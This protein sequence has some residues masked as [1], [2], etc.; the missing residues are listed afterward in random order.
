VHEVHAGGAVQ[1]PCATAT[2]Q[3]EEMAGE[4][5]SACRGLQYTSGPMM[6]PI[7]MHNPARRPFACM[8]STSA[9]KKSAYRCASGAE[10]YTLLQHTQGAARQVPLC[11]APSALRQVLP[12]CPA[13][14]GAGGG[15]MGTG[16]G[17]S[18]ST[19]CRR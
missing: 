16:P 17:Y 19:P 10:Q 15:G 9:R 1:L 6:H 2:Y 11:Q 4:G 8:P 14:P 18:R 12:L 7:S 13:V 5:E 3:Y